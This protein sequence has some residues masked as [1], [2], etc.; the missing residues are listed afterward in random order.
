MHARALE[1]LPELH[2]DDQRKFLKK[3]KTEP[4]L[5]AAHTVRELLLGVFFKQ[6]GMAPRHEFVIEGKTPDWT[7]FESENVIAI[8]DQITLHQTQIL[9]DEINSSLRNGQGWV[10]WVPDSTERLYQKVLEKAEKYADLVASLSK[11]YAVSAFIDVNVALEP[12]E[13]AN[14]LKVMHG[15]GVFASCPHLSGVL[16]SS[17]RWGKYLFQYTANERAGH[18]FRLRDLEV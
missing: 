18:A 1:L 4:P 17:E 16:V 11:P 8:A 15:G 9:N 7:L 2:Q 10:G 12:D 6:S 3:L 13:V 5:Q 14:A